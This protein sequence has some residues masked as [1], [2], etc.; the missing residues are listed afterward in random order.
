VRVLNR[1]GVAAGAAVVLLLLLAT[2]STFASGQ[3]ATR[4]MSKAASRP[5]TLSAPLT[6]AIN[7]PVTTPPG[8]V[9][10]TPTG[11]NMVTAGGETWTF[12]GINLKLEQQLYWGPIPSTVGYPG[13]IDLAMDGTVDAIDGEALSYNAVQPNLAAGKAYWTGTAPF[14]GATWATRFTLTVTNSAGTSPIP[15]LDAAGLGISNAGAVVHVTG[16][17]RAN[18][19]MEVAPPSTGVFATPVP[20]YDAAIPHTDKGLLSSFDGGF[21]VQQP[22]LIALP[23]MANGAYGGYTTAT[24]LQN[25]GA[26]TANVVVGYFD[27]A[28]NPVGAGDSATIAPK[29]AAITRQDNGH[30][31]ASGQAGS[32]LVYSDQPLTGFVNEFPPG[33]TGDATSY[34]GIAFPSAVAGTIYAPAIASA[35]YGGYTTGIGLINLG[36]TAANIT[37]TYRDS[38]GAVQGIPQSLTGVAP[39]AYRGVYSGNSGSGT[40]A[41]LPAGFAGTATL[42]SD[43]SQ[44][45]AAVVNETGPGAQ[46]SSYDAISAGR[47]T[48]YAP[49]ALRNAYGGFNTGMGIQN[50]TALASP[51]TISYYDSTGTATT[52]TFNIAAYGYLGVYQGTDIPADGAYTAVITA[53]STGAALAAIVN[54]VAPGAGPAFQSTAYNTSLGGAATIELPL[55]ESTGPDGWSTGEGIMNTG[56][57]A[58]TVTVTYYDTT[59]GTVVGTP[60][61]NTLAVN[62]F[63][64]LYQPVG[65]LPS[66]TRATA[67]ITN[68]SGGL[69]SVITNESNANTFMSYNGSS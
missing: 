30:S 39:G 49:V 69:V 47:T 10:L 58:T 29:G 61:T 60:Q 23:A 2:D 12:A 18:L 22:A 40:D 8:G 53:P 4:T 35:A 1:L 9:T 17:F 43:A 67:V 66:G 7:P 24:Y 44:P 45:L 63:W 56:S 46:F 42:S 21:Y 68:S 31:F 28:G 65:G 62:A 20:Q 16:D 25:V 19:L 5:A 41:N 54:E 27:Q 38:S 51:V 48:L 14:N 37:I 36:T 50:T 32:A 34:T 57:A 6:A 15:L 11:T 26:G 55:V 13:P 52:K 64:G 3:A 59:A 33:G